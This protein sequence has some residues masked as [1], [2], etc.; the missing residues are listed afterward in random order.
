MA[1]PVGPTRGDRS[2]DKILTNISHDE[3]EAGTVPPLE[4]EDACAKKSDHRIAYLKTHIQRAQTFEWVSYCYRYYNEASVEKFK[5]WIVLEPW[6][7]VL[8]AQG[9]NDKAD[10]YTEEVN[11]AVDRY[12]PLIHTR[13]KSTDFPWINKAIRKRIR[14]RRAIYRDEGRSARLW[15]LKKTIEDMIRRRQDAY[16]LYQRQFILDPDSSRHFFRNVKSLPYVEK[17]KQFDVRSLFPGADDAQIAE[18]LAQYFNGISQE[19]SPLE[20]G[21]IPVTRDVP[22]PTLQT[23]EVAARIRKFRKPRSMVGGDIFPKLLTLFSDF[24][25]ILLTSIFNTI[26]ETLVWPRDWKIEY[27]TAIPKKTHPESL[28]DLRNIL[29]TMLPSKI[30]ESYVLEWSMLEVKVRQNQF[31]GVK[32]TGAPH[33]LISIWQDVLEHLEDYRA[34]SVITSIDYAKA[35]NRLSFQHCL[36]S[37][38]KKGASSRIIRLLST[39]LS[40]RTMKVRVGP[41]SYLT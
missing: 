9:S 23:F 28:N 22:L 10:R 17:P 2:I 16:H 33:M 14:K 8:Q 27:V 4:S 1:A 3:S 31:G 18:H 12:F 30:Y 7:D 20:P 35:F 38:A 36:A 6:N 41:A 40:G 25:A 24:F 32:G 15:R 21:D 26:T 11:T 34:A 19:F 13:R 29:C 5:Q 39:F 37:F